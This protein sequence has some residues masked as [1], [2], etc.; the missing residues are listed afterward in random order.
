M[1]K[2]LYTHNKLRYWYAYDIDEICLHF[3]DKGLH[4]QTVRKWI[5]SGLDTIDSKKPCLIY[6]YYLIDYLKNQN[7]KNKCQTEFNQFYCFKCQ[8]A[9]PIYQKRVAL[10][11]ETPFLK[12]KA[13]CREC[14]TAMHKSYKIDDFS[15]LKQKSRLGG[16]VLNL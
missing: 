12:A 2:R 3:K 13:I 11:Q 6:G 15:R 16:S 14:K 4:A 10:T 7:S 5:K 9:R 1:S 8:D